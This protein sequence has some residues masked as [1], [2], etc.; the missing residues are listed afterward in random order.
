[1]S[2]Q[3]ITVAFHVELLPDEDVTCYYCGGLT[4]DAQR[5]AVRAANE[6]ELVLSACGYHLPYILTNWN[7]LPEAHHD[8]D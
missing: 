6:G 7:D 3:R 4:F 2:E 8:D 5:F 1:M